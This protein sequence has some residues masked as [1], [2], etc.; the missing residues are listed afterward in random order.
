MKNLVLV[1]AILV[2]VAIAVSVLAP[3]NSLSRL[4]RSK[5]V[6]VVTGTNRQAALIRRHPIIISSRALNRSL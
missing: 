1:V 2:L 4:F 5:E 6:V 3:G